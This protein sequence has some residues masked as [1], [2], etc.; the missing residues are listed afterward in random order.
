MKD[1]M[2][3]ILNWVTLF[4][5]LIWVGMNVIGVMFPE[6]LERVLE[7]DDKTVTLVIGAVVGAGGYK[8]KT[9]V[10]SKEVE[11]EYSVPPVTQD[12]E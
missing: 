4:A 6:H 2:S 3:K 10:D 5:I 7:F 12:Y 8:L 11:T 9:I 1:L